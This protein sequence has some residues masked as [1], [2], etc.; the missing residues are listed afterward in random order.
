MGSEP[1]YPTGLVL[2]NEFTGHKDVILRLSWSADGTKLASTSVDQT[3]CLWDVRQGQK[4]LTLGGH[5]GGV[6]LAVWSPGGDL[7]ASSSFDRTVRLWNPFTGAEIWCWHDHN[8]DVPS[9]AWSP[10]G[11]LLASGSIDRTIAIHNV[12]SKD[13]VC[14]LLGHRDGITRVRWFR[15]GNRL[16]SCGMDKRV[17]LW[18]LRERRCVESLRG[19]ADGVIDVCISPNEELLASSS[20]DRTIRI[21]RVGA[22]KSEQIR[23]LKGHLDSVR[24]VSFSADGQ[25]LASNSNDGT[26]WIWRTDIWE[27]VAKFD[28][29]T[30]FFWPCSL[31]FSPVEPLLATFGQGDRSIRIWRINFAELPSASIVP[32]VEYTNAKVV[33]VGESGCGK[34]AL[35]DA[36]MKRQFVP[37]AATHGLKVMTLDSQVS[38]GDDGT[39]RIRETLLWDLA[40]QYDYQLVHQLFLD[41]TS[42]ALVVFDPNRR[43]RFE[44][45]AYWV[46]ALQRILGEGVPCILVAARVDCGGVIASAKEIE[47]LKR[48]YGFVGFVK[49][50]S[51]EPR[52]GI[53][54]LQE[55]IANTIPWDRLPVTK[56]PELW[57]AIR[58]YLLELRQQGSL[59]ATPAQLQDDFRQRRP[60]NPFTEGEFQA[61]LANAQT[62]GL[63]WKLKMVDLVLL[64]PELLNVCA[65]SIA[66]A[67]RSDDLGTVLEKDVLSGKLPIKDLD[68]L[69]AENAKDLLFAVVQLL[70][71]REIVL[72]EGDFLVFPSKIN[73]PRPESAPEPAPEVVFS[74]SGPVED[75]Y[76]TLIVR[77]AYC[78]TFKLGQ[79]WDGCAEFGLAGNDHQICGLK[80]SSPEAAHGHLGLYFMGEVSGDTKRLFTIFVEEHLKRRSLAGVK[81]LRLHQC[82]VCQS[83]TEAPL[84]ATFQVN[85][86]RALLTCQYE[87]KAESDPGDL[88]AHPTDSEINRVHSLEKLA[89]IES[90]NQARNYDVFYS[91]CSFDLSIVSETVEEL[92][93]RE[94]LGWFDTWHMVPGDDVAK[95]I[96]RAMCASSVVVVFV[97]ERIG[98]YQDLEVSI[99]MALYVRR[100]TRIIPVK[101]T[102]TEESEHRFGLEIFSRV[103]F[104]S[105]PADR[106][107]ISDLERGI[108][109]GRQVSQ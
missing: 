98:Q 17:R 68:Q 41:E 15:D 11:R 88:G 109:A 77:L 63:V 6:N 95:K 69:S 8:D 2:L 107:K 5:H 96:E 79:R 45:V 30:S 33:L 60:N 54:E 38:S 24:S 53:L 57:N 29:P 61:V 4:I 22:G 75:I 34:S 50:S 92:K 97:G 103:D 32:T 37:Q 42:L 31:A 89:T 99:A 40:G 52:I 73:E 86:P 105:W 21:W 91:Y 48:E 47:R 58:E 67:A 93:R 83:Q 35:A 66:L 1:K 7:L 85:S 25:L 87:E 72:R 55:L 10:D 106:G 49:T 74:F 12:E 81:R 16:V 80:L 23:I 18:D 100:K 76:A 26:V 19:H 71:R 27:T 82:P 65:S 90:L 84:K 94:I 102:A 20:F 70:V 39:K 28:E 36:L 14:K 3:I 56:S 108:R 9:V 101:L 46:R 62:Q 59:L 64:K 51:M 104:T 78:G 44:G 43:A 13:L